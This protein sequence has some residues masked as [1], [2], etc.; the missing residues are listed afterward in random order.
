MTTY[1]TERITVDPDI[2]NG[3]PTVRGHRLTVQSMLEFLSAGDTTDDL[4]AAYPFLES[5][6]IQA[7]LQYAAQ[8]LARQHVLRVAA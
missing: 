7:C 8:L 5:A 1:L 2:C 6:D 4:L 3:K